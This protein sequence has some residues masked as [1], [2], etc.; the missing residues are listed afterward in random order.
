MVDE[1]VDNLKKI[2]LALESGTSEDKMNL[3]SKP[4]EYEFVFGT[5]S[6][7]ITPFEYELANRSVGDEISLHVRKSE[8]PSFF[9]HLAPG[10]NERVESSDSFYLKVKIANISAAD[11]REIV[12]A[13]AGNLTHGDDCGCGCGC[14]EH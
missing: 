9:E 1:K 5:G 12:K 10:I 6:E 2:T 14:G 3:T 11:N 4:V 8:I 13:L 7:G